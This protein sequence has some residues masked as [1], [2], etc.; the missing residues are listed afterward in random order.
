[1]KKNR[2]WELDFLRGLSIILLVFDHLMFYITMIPQLFANYY[3]VRN[4]FV[5]D[6]VNKGYLYWESAIRN[7]G[8]VIFV[9][10]FLGLV[11]ISSTFSHNNTKRG[12]KIFLVA[13]GLTLVTYVLQVL[14]IDEVLILFG[15]L[16]LIGIGILCYVLI[17]KLPCSKL[18]FLVGGVSLLLVGL[19]HNMFFPPYVAHIKD[20]EDF[21]E[22]V[23][24]NI[25]SGGDSFGLYYISLIFIGAFLGKTLYENKKSLLPKLDGKWNKPIC[26]CG[27]NTLL[28]YVISPVVSF[29]VIIGVC[30]CLGYRF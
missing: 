26:C 22:L 23:V 8:H 24:G 5:M 19:E 27:R 14:G 29:I 1:M 25:M 18:I 6:L 4:G 3:S 28:V 2:I 7:I 17:D 10:I 11:G 15:I 21:C 30:L 9:S 13:L 16:H 12:I 20:F